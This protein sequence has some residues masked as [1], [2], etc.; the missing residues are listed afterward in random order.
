MS[1][2]CNRV[3]KV[4]LLSYCLASLGLYAQAYAAA[5]DQDE[6]TQLD[7]ITLTATADQAQVSQAK[8]G[9]TLHD[10]PHS[11][12]VF[13]AQ[14]M[15]QKNLQSLDEV[16]QNTSGVTTQPFQLLTT[17]YYTR[18][19]KIDSFAQNGTPIL[20]GNMASA[21]QD[22]AMYEQ[23]E[24]IKGAN[25]L[26]QGTGNPAATVN[27]VAKRPLDHVAA[28]A[29]LGYGRWD[30]LNSSLDLNLPLSPDARVK[31]RFVASYTDKDFFYDV[32]KQRSE[33]YYGVIDF[34]LT[35]QM[36]LYAGVHDQSIRG[37]TN[38]AGVPFYADGSDMHLP[39]HTYLDVSWDRF[40]WDN[41]RVFAGIDYKFQNAWLLNV[42]YN[43]FDGDAELDYAGATGKVDPNTGLGLKLTGGSYLFKNKQDSLDAYV[44]GTVQLWQRQHELLFG[45]QYQKTSTE[46]WSA[47][48]FRLDPNIAVDPWHWDPSQVAQPYMGN[49]M[50]R[51]PE[52]IKQLGFY[53]TGR[54]ALTDQLKAIIGGRVSNWEHQANNQVN[55]LDHEVTPYAGLVYQLNPAWM[56][57]VSYAQIFQP[58][59]QR[60][61]NDE[62]LDPVRGSTTELGIKADLWQQRLSLN[63]SVYQ[64]IQQDRA[65]ED[66]AH[67]CVS[68]FDTAC[69]IAD[70]RVRS[71]GFELEANTQL[72]P[73]FTLNAS[74]SNNHSK[75]LR[76]AESAGEAFAS[77]APRH[78]FN[79]W[80]NYR[81]E[82]L[83]Q[84]L[85][86]GLGLRAQSDFYT[87][88][89]AVR[90]SQG[91]Y[92]VFD[93]SARYQI[94]SHLEA[95][96]NI[97]NL[98][99]RR[100]YHSLSGVNWNNRYGEPRAAMFSLRANF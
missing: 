71:R 44:K 60:S 80:A 97:K 75:Y 61:Y 16:M 79:L 33:N 9:D 43:R 11:V 70:G 46:Q 45:A 66:P 73:S 84:R 34:D 5:T 53:A 20:M 51:G 93:A 12:K 24:I 63:A 95:A 25:G 96:L 3:F 88:S 49:Y 81:P 21:P 50:S 37:G 32:S 100:Y 77:F 1:T 64:I 76:D 40:D 7:T 62:L 69:Y 90:L 52:N 48:D 17:S 28:Q 92:S 99:D 36:T 42:Q 26:L 68:S 6:P 83:Q 56:T 2:L 65:Q 85:T 27:L 72:S 23:V 41:T 54:F 10:I 29:T 15:Q 18:G 74:Y 13:S 78:M 94:N 55:K 87:Q 8:L 30:H 39:R 98:F 58:Q 57:Y 31:S 89:G 59:Q 22:M 82:S 4:S 47:M 67:P 38:M 35:E 91:G 86:L 14:E 19:F